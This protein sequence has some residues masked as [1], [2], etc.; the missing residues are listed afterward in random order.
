MDDKPF[1]L[2]FLNPA[3]HIEYFSV[4]LKSDMGLRCVLLDINPIPIRE[5]PT[6]AFPIWLCYVVDKI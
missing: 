3:N 6:R 4:I 5:I 2:F 1:T